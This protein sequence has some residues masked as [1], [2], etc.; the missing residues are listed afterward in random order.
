[1]LFFLV[2]VVFIIRKY[3]FSLIFWENFVF[4]LSNVGIILDN[5]YLSF[6]W[7]YFKRDCFD[8]FNCGK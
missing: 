3:F 1:M 8:S 5:K 6:F 7:F 2:Y 4:I